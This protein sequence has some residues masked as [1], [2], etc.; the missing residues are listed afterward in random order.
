MN[1]APARPAR[2]PLACRTRSRFAAAED[3]RNGRILIVEDRANAA[4]RM[5]VALGQQHVCD[6][7]DDPGDL[8]T[9]LLARAAI[10]S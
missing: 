1:C 7:I 3:G 10:A 6:C 2:R 9:R 5:K 4:D 8:V